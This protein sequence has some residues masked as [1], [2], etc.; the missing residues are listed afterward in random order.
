MLRGKGKKKTGSIRL[1]CTSRLG[2]FYFIFESTFTSLY[3]EYYIKSTSSRD[4]EISTPS[5]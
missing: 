5:Q 1:R 4:R 2:V 3:S